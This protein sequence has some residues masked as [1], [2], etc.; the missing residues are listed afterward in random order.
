MTWLCSKPNPNSRLNRMIQS[1][2]QTHLSPLFGHLLFKL[3]QPSQ[4]LVYRT[5]INKFILKYL[6][7]VHAIMVILPRE[8]VRKTKRSLFFPMWCFFC[9]F[10]YNNVSYSIEVWFCES[11][12]HHLQQEFGK[13][14][15]NF[16][17]SKWKFI[18]IVSKDK[19]SI[20]V[21]RNYLKSQITQKE[22][23]RVIFESPN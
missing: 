10:T 14:Y 12:E 16:L 21:L 20:E 6:I 19:D 5:T 22:K 1:K 7:T 11:S 4:H 13:I 23:V 3:I 17:N 8:K 2:E 9:T 18:T 15:F